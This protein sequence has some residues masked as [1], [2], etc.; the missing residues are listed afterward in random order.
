MLLDSK[1]PKGFTNK[2]PLDCK[3]LL[4]KSYGSKGLECG[5]TVWDLDLI[6]G[7]SSPL[8]LTCV[9]QKCPNYFFLIGDGQSC[10]LIE[11]WNVLLLTP[12]VYLEPYYRI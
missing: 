2:I 10:V 1:I 4:W 12:T 7:F 3:W 9:G 5:S 8:L 11:T 6:I